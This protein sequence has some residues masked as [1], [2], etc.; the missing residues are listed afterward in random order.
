[1]TN[2]RKLSDM[3]GNNKRNFTRRTEGK[4]YVELWIDTDWWDAPY[5]EEK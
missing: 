3:L 4:P 5:E 2:G 1:M